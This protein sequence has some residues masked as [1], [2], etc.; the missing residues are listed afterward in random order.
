MIRSAGVWKRPLSRITAGEGGGEGSTFSPTRRSAHPRRLGSLTRTLSRKSCGR[1]ELASPSRLGD[2]GVPSRQ[3]SERLLH[4][5]IDT[6]IDLANAEA[7]VVLG[8]KT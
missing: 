4:R 6:Q 2:L 7:I 8:R 1:G 3:D 5:S